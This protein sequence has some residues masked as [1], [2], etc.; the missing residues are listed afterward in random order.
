MDSHSD[1]ESTEHIREDKLHVQKIFLKK[2]SLQIFKEWE[3]SL[4]NVLDDLQDLFNVLRQHRARILAGF[5]K[6]NSG[7]YTASHFFPSISIKNPFTGAHLMYYFIL[8]L[9]F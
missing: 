6:R 3:E 5:K 9:F 1:S 2:Q 7:K 4:G 8:I